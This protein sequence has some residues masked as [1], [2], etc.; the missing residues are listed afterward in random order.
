MGLAHLINISVLAE[1]SLNSGKVAAIG[2]PCS[3][4]EDREVLPAVLLTQHPKPHPL[5]SLLLPLPLS[6]MALARKRRAWDFLDVPEERWTLVPF[7]WNR[8]HQME[9]P[10]R[11]YREAIDQL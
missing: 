9:E 11:R 8:T 6:S 1:V 10:L 2:D 7:H 4:P 3:G 5:V